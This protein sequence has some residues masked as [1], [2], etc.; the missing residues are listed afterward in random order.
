MTTLIPSHASGSW[1]GSHQR[2]EL[3]EFAFHTANTLRN[4]GDI[5]S[6]PRPL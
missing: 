6:A 1:Q 5:D 4:N 2:Y 3:L